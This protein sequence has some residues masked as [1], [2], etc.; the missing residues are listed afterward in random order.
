MRAH[1]HRAVR[2]REAM[3]C[4]DGLCVCV[5]EIRRE[6]GID[7]RSEREKER[8]GGGGGGE[9][10]RQRQRETR[11]VR[12][13]SDRESVERPGRARDT[14][15]E[16][17]D[18][19]PN[20]RGVGVPDRRMCTCARARTRM[21]EKIESN[22]YAHGHA[23][24]CVHLKY[25]LACQPRPRAADRRPC[26]AC[27]TRPAAINAPPLIRGRETERRNGNGKHKS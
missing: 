21:C 27:R 7:S 10:E 8:G 12:R 4:T 18:S 15:V 26:P 6:G 22:A 14:G 23:R 19:A 2:K 16:N 1:R 20:L 3:R 24:V 25:D 11:A 9:R 5:R 17:R 13:E